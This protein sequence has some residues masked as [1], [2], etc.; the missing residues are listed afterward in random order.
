MSQTIRQP[1]REVPFLLRVLWFFLL[2]WETAGI[3]ILIAWALNLT[4]IGLPLGLW[5]I[6][7]VPQV[8][9]LKARSGEWVTHKGGGTH[10][11][12]PQ[13]HPFLLRAVY[14][15]LVGWW[16]SLIW[17]AL[18]YLLSVTIIGLPF[19]I[20]MLHALPAVTTLHKN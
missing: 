16:F 20:P 13:Q 14:F 18:G 12:T 2:G 1:V 6:D 8:L 15:V 10:H 5:M 17:A 11:V 3:W 9:T 7:R 4:I 19:G